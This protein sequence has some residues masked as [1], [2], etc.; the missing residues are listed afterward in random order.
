M[1]TGGPSGHRGDTDVSPQ[2]C[3]GATFWKSDKVPNKTA[4][5][6]RGATTVIKIES[7]TRAEQ[8]PFVVQRLMARV[9]LA[10]RQLCR[11]VIFK[12]CS[13][14]LSPYVRA[15]ACRK[16]LLCAWPKQDMSV[17]IC[18]WFYCKTEKKM[19]L[20][21]A[22]TDSSNICLF[23][24]YIYIYI[25][26]QSEEIKMNKL[27]TRSGFYLQMTHNYFMCSWVSGRLFTQDGFFFS[28]QGARS[29]KVKI[30]PRNWQERHR[31]AKNRVDKLSWDAKRWM[32]SIESNEYFTQPFSIRAFQQCLSVK[33]GG[34]KEIKT[35]TSKKYI[36]PSCHGCPYGQK[37]RKW[38][39][40]AVCH[41]RCDWVIASSLPPPQCYLAQSSAIP[42][43]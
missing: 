4:L 37:F 12:P 41:L 38:L 30:C 21:W 3:S 35:Q 43:L 17:L 32:L 29:E 1:T 39:W 25:K 9:C 42:P 27:Q 11:H 14:C 24:G 2:F 31:A 20:S 36:F 16:S 26:R 34:R 18:W 19:A 23:I 22:F 15:Q 5:R 13:K 28:V 10:K 6:E 7:W 40:Q 33:R 8:K